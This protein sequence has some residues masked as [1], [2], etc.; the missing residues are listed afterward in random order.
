MFLWGGDGGSVQ[1]AVE[2]VYSDRAACG[3]LKFLWAARHA[4]ALPAAFEVAAVRFGGSD[5]PLLLVCGARF[6]QPAHPCETP[7]PSPVSSPPKHTHT[8]ARPHPAPTDPATQTYPVC[9][10]TM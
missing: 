6:G 7:H 9:C 8:P 2:R 5:S 10:V 1:A 3:S 4:T